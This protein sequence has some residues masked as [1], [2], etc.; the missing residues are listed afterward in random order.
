MDIPTPIKDLQ[1]L[2]IPPHW[3][4]RVWKPF[5]EKYNCQII[6]E[7]GVQEG[8]NFS[9]MIQHDPR[10]AVAV[11]PWKD[12]G[13][14]SR[15]SS[16]YSQDALDQQYEN[17]NTLAK[18]KGYIK[19]IRDYSFN[20]A[21]GFPDDFF[22]IVY[23]DADHTYDAVLQDLTDWYPKVKKGRFIIGDDYRRDGRRTTNGVRWGVVSATRDF[24]IKNKLVVYQLPRWN[25]CMIK[26]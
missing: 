1:M 19:V 9:L 18:E 26:K 16:G 11:D 7:I 8:V 17:M 25:W 4:C 20:A 3:R 24:A 14:R 2:E 15:N 23:I 5:M 13:F 12:D 10:L 6:C 21:R 22:D